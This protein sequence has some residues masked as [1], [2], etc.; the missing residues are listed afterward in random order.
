M[1]G[2]MCIQE[3]SQFN[4]NNDTRVFT[5]K[6]MWC[7]QT[8]ACGVGVVTSENQLVTSYLLLSSHVT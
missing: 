5:D 6:C 1:N 2:K 3:S 7:W 8:S 4:D